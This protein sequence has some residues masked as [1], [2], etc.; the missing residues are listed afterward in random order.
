MIY[1]PQGQPFDG[2][3]DDV[4]I[5]NRVLSA[6]EISGIYNANLG[7]ATCS[8]R[9]FTGGN[10]SCD[11]STCK[12][13]TSKCTLPPDYNLKVDPDRI[14]AV[15]KQSSTVNSTQTDITL[16]ASEYSSGATFYVTLP[17]GA[18]SGSYNITIT[19][20]GVIPPRTVTLTLDVS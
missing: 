10:L 4:R 8:S 19:G 12:F 20:D 6:A 16:S 5:Y 7:G 3:I 13:D 15:V 18:P 2:L 17:A 9:G 1:Q 14:T 11:A